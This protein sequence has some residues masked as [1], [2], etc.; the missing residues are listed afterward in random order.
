MKTSAITQDHL[1]QA[2]C[3][4]LLLQTMHSVMRRTLLAGGEIEPG[5]RV[6][7]PEALMAPVPLAAVLVCQ[8]EDAMNPVALVRTL[9]YGADVRALS[10]EGFR[11]AA[12]AKR[13]TNL[14]VYRELV[15]VIAGEAARCIAEYLACLQ[16][17]GEYGRLESFARESARLRRSLRALRAAGWLYRFHAPHAADVGNRALDAIGCAQ[18]TMR[19]LCKSVGSRSI[20]PIREE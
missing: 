11:A 1:F 14:R 20:V 4:A 17:S 16:R 19:E 18:N 5:P 7:K 12:R 10:A 9:L 6:L 3:A 8:D 2:E 15:G 13:R